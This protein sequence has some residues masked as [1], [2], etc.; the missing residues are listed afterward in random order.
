[1]PKNRKNV[2]RILCINVSE[3]NT[4]EISSLCAI[5]EKLALAPNWNGN[6]FLE[7]PNYSQVRNHTFASSENWLWE[8]SITAISPEFWEFN[9]SYR[10]EGHLP[11]HNHFK[12]FSS[13]S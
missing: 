2:A 5:S 11:K 12:P 6:R 13:N 3:R 7:Y 4:C 8:K 9:I 10:S 1:M